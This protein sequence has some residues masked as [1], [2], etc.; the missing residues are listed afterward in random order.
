VRILAAVVVLILAAALAA[1]ATH[2]L[3]ALSD[4]VHT[5]TEGNHS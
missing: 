3:A 1:A 4:T 2:P 5:L